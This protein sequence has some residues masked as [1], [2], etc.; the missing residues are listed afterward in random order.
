LGIFTLIKSVILKINELYQKNNF[1]LV[2][3]DGFGGSGKT[4]FADLLLKG[5]E[6]CTIVQLDDFYSPSLHAADILRLKEQILLPFHMHQ[7]AKYQIYEWKT[8]T[9]S[10]WRILQPEGIFIF[11]GVYALD[12]DIREYYD[13]TIWIDYPV[14]LGFRRG[15]ARDINQD[16]VDNS[17]KWKK[18][19]MPLEVKYEK[20]QNP[21]RYADIV[22]DGLRLFP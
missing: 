8:D 1:V 14:D 5:L 22:V 19:W 12:K 17:D 21:K 7:E 11:E 9:L 2:A 13:L 4:T 20:E 18:E 3:I 6:N 10:N 16:G 15:I